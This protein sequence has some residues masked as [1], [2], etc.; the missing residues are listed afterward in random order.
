MELKDTVTSML[1]DDYKERFKAEYNQ[2]KIRYEKLNNM[3]KKWDIGDLNF[4]P[5]CPRSVYETQTYA[6][7]TYLSCLKERAVI[8]GIEL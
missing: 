5:N 4:M 2:L 6:M 8:E 7:S 3:L 1:S